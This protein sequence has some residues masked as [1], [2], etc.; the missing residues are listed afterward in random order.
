MSDLAPRRHNGFTLVELLVV[1]GVIAVLISLLLPALNKARDSATRANCASR[2]RQ[3]ATAVHIYADNCRGALPAGNRD[4][5]PDQH[6]IW[7]SQ[8]T[9]EALV[10]YASAKVLSCPNLEETQPNKPPSEIGWVLGYAYLGGKPKL[11]AAHGWRSPLKASEKA[12]LPVFCDLNDWSPL[13][14]WMAVGHLKNGGADFT[15]LTPNRN[16]WRGGNVACLDGSVAWKR[17][18]EMTRHETY[19]GT[20]GQYLGMW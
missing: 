2:L 10:K 14:G 12:A 11:T 18:D 20:T 16:S 4:N 15:P 8:A 7:V 5:N 19:S 3:L 13:D 6:T 1:I 9:Y 17:V